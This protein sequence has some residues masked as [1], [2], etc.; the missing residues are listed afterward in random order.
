[1]ALKDMLH[2][3]GG[4]AKELTDALM[5]LDAE[6]APIRVEIENTHTRFESRLTIKRESVV[7]FKPSGL[8]DQLQAGSFVRFRLPHDMSRE[9][10]L[11]V[12]TP[13]VNLASGT[14]LFLCKMP[15][16]G[17]QPA[18]RNAERYNVTKFKNVLLTL[19]KRG[20][21]FRVVDVSLSGCK[22]FSTQ[23]EAN[24]Y[25][26]I[27]KELEFV[28]LSLG[29]KVKVD[30]ERLVPRAHLRQTV[31]CEFEISGEGPSKVHM[32][33][34]IKSLEKFEAR[35]VHGTEQISVQ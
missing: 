11:E 23:A 35:N 2:G 33:S 34:L 9:V 30:L 16:T 15:T 26:P 28:Q 10:R 25:F 12:A 20:R 8:R 18:K 1:M 24:S 7:V 3:F 6:M 5:R 14:S 31:G 17:L 19:G 32:Q 22:V 29:Q 27:G 4:S 21:S 13:H